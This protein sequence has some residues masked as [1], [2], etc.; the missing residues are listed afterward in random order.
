[1]EFDPMKAIKNTVDFAAIALV[2]LSCT[3]SGSDDAMFRGDVARTG[4]YDTKAVHELNEIMWKFKTDDNVFPS[5][6]I[7]DG[8]V[9]VGS[10]D[11]NLYALK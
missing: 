6:S 8:V 7:S 2:A 10:E 4:V 9:Y 11:D 1:M 5:P 3:T